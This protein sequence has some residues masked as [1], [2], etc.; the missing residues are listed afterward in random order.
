LMEYKKKTSQISLANR[1]MSTCVAA[2][3]LK[4]VLRA[5]P[6]AVDLRAPSEFSQAARPCQ[7]YIYISCSSDSQID[8]NTR[9]LLHT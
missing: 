1:F 8:L 3:E 4:V 9:A 7:R 6:A 2:N 5:K